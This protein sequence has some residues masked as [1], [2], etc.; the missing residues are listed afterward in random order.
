MR[1][2]T[3]TEKNKRW[4]E[5][6]R[7]WR[8]HYVNGLLHQDQNDGRQIQVGDKIAFPPIMSPALV[9]LIIHI[10]HEVLRRQGIL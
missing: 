1:W 9:I 5:L 6:K 7:E 10:T 2:V 8:E 4:L 3:V